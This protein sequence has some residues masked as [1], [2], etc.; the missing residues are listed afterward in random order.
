M[1]IHNSS[2]D[3]FS[4]LF[5][6]YELLGVASDWLQSHGCVREGLGVL[7]PFLGDAVLAGMDSDL[8][9]KLLGTVGLAH[10]RLGEVEK[11]IGYQEQAL[12]IS[13]EIDDRQGEGTRL[14]NLSIGYA[15]LGEVEKA[16]GYLEQ[17]MAIGEQIGDPRIVQNA[18][19]ALEKLSTPEGPESDA[20]GRG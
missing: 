2:P 10:Q 14:G 19:H 15:R 4:Y 5:F 17:A 11:A 12:A 1:G 18:A 3:P 7:T 9:G 16:I 6:A 13:R 8:T 20:P